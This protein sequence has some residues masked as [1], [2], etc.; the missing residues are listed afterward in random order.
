MVRCYSLKKVCYY[1]HT[2]NDNRILLQPIAGSPSDYINASYINVRD[3]SMQLIW[4]W[5]AHT[6]AHTLA[7]TRM[8]THCWLNQDLFSL[9]G[10]SS[11]KK[12]IGTQGTQA[13]NHKKI[14]S[15]MYIIARLTCAP[16]ILFAHSK[17]FIWSST[18]R[19][20]P[21]NGYWFLEDGVAGETFC[22]CDAHKL[23]RR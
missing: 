16:Y 17:T 13:C 15:H 21:N 20:P 5:Y 3:Y 14:S 10:Y 19:S 11:P 18:F 4:S 12:F 23:G 22:N 8:H 9:Q 6:H 1:I 7:H 2:D